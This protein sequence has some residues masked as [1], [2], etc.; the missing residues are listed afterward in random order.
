MNKSLVLRYAK[1]RKFGKIM[2]LP[3]TELQP[4]RSEKLSRLP[5]G[6]EIKPW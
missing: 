3:L 5:T 2:A 1:R 4:Y 6:L